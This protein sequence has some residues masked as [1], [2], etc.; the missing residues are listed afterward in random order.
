LLGKVLKA[1]RKNLSCVALGL[2]I[3]VYFVYYYD[4]LG[5]QDFNGNLL[6]RLLKYTWIRYLTL[7]VGNYNRFF[8]VSELANDINSDLENVT[9]W[10]NV[11]KFQSHP[12]KG[13]FIWEEV[14]PVSEKTFRL[15]K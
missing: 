12:S 3:R 4:K 15:A 10:I 9:D 14:I 5:W 6:R 13:L 8:I 11:N 2:H 7:K 1:A